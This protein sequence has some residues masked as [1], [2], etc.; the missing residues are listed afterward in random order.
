M[1]Y[2]NRLEQAKKQRGGNGSTAGT[3]THIPEGIPMRYT[4]ASRQTTT[5]FTSNAHLQETPARD[6]SPGPQRRRRPQ[7][8]LGRGQ[9]PLPLFAPRVAA[10]D[11]GVSV[12]GMYLFTPPRYFRSLVILQPGVG[13]TLSRAYGRRHQL[14]TAGDTSG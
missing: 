9:D 3:P 14:M 2:F 12:V 1:S 8:S 6:E 7:S 10:K 4:T 5:P 11:S 13:T